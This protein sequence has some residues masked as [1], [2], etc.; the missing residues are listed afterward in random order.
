MDFDCRLRT[1]ATRMR[2]RVYTLAETVL[3]GTI[4]LHD[5][6]GMIAQVSTHTGTALEAVQAEY[7][8]CPISAP[9][10]QSIEPSDPSPHRLG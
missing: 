8:R 10:A 2:A 1:R 4:V 3:V 6:D 7:L 9:E 5:E